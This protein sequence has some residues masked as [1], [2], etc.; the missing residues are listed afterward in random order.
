M[1]HRP[2]NGPSESRYSQKATAYSLFFW[3]LGLLY[4]THERESSHGGGFT[5]THDSESTVSIKIR[6]TPFESSMS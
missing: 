3:S 5:A 6:R 2:G 1:N 4:R